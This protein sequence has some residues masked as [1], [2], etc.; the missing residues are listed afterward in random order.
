VC[1]VKLFE[2]VSR[3]FLRNKTIL[4]KNLADDEC[5][6]LFPLPQ[7][8][9]EESCSI[10]LSALNTL[11]HHFFRDNKVGIDAMCKSLIS[12]DRLLVV[13]YQAK[14]DIPPSFS[15]SSSV[16]I[17]GNDTQAA[18]DD[19]QKKPAA[20]KTGSKLKPPPVSASTAPQDDFNTSTSA[21]AGGLAGSISTQNLAPSVG[22]SKSA[23]DTS[24]NSGVAFSS[25]RVQSN[26]PSCFNPLMLNRSRVDLQASEVERLFNESRQRYVHNTAVGQLQGGDTVT[27]PV[28]QALYFKEKSDAIG[29]FMLQEN[30]SHV[31]SKI[32]ILIEE[33][34]ELKI[35][36][37]GKLPSTGAT[38]DR[39][40]DS[41]ATE[42][43][44]D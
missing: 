17:S 34:K 7:S 23:A 32:D 38:E 18:P 35:M 28:L 31:D 19:H 21:T 40:I 13:C 14:S 8:D 16:D 1:Q 4:E 27:N 29:F 2:I 36:L 20:V 5:R 33:M 25:G 30:V 43:N 37:L 39:N 26:P 12:F 24:A 42:N 9:W 15:L 41:A 22:F 3:S 11:A 44:N 6:S 10:H